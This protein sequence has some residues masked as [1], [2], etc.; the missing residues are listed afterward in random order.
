MKKPLN[1]ILILRQNNFCFPQ[2]NL[3]VYFLVMVILQ[4]IQ[5]L[6]TDTLNFGFFKYIT[7]NL[8]ITLFKFTLLSFTV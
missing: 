4:T 8:F 7:T 3:T 5:I 1:E 6:L 2:T